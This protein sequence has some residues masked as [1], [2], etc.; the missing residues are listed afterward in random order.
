MSSV[1]EKKG[2]KEVAAVVHKPDARLKKKKSEIIFLTPRSFSVGENVHCPFL[3]SIH[4]WNLKKKSVKKT[5]KSNYKTGTKTKK[6]RDN[7]KL[8]ILLAVVLFAE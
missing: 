3:F 5:L 7:F 6:C 8:L 1:A 2:M 4:F